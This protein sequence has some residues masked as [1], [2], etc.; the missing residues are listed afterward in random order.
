MLAA[1]EQG[2]YVMMSSLLFEH[3]DNL[4]EKNILRVAKKHGL[5]TQKLYKDAHSQKIKEE[6]DDNIKQAVD[7]GIN[8][9]PS[10][11]IGVK[12]YNYFLSFDELYAIVSE[13]KDV[14][15]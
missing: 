4:S 15:K 3:S 13:Y 8:S 10:A 6:L 12:I 7:T 9:T 14:V 5:D 11:K 1:K 2:K